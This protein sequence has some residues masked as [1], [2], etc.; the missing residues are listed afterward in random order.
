[1]AETPA[2]VKRDI[3]LTRD[4]ISDTLQQ[5][6]AKTNVMQIV[7]D[8]PW[9]ALGVAFAAGF[10]LSGTRADV[11]A[12]SATL[13][14][15]QG[16]RSRV[17]TVLDDVLANLM[18]GLSMAFQQRVDSLVGELKQAIGGAEVQGAGTRGAASGSQRFAE[19]DVTPTAT[20][21]DGVAAAGTTG[22]AE[23][24]SALGGASQGGTAGST[25]MG[26]IG[27][28]HQSGGTLSSAGSQGATTGSDWSP[29]SSNLEGGRRAD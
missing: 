28:A 20:R 13:V 8:H 23:A 7:K 26:V 10:L 21:G 5:L 25:G 16:T 27:N 6:E 17:G 12:A 3:E 29:Q 18:G 24:R 9:P 1:M 14:A 4:R 22:A 11:K 2:D 15:T 19:T